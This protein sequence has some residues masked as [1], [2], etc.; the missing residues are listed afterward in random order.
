MVV[1]RLQQQARTDALGVHGVAAAL[2]GIG[3]AMLGQGDLEQAHIRLGFENLQGLGRE[4]R[5]H[6]HFDELLADLRGGS[7]VHRTVEGDDA[8]KS[9]GRVGLE[10]LV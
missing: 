10:G 2:P 1:C 8:A 4:I 5:G 3:A 7:T 6:Q 9:A